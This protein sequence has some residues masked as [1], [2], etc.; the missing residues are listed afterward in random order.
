[1]KLL[2]A[3][4]EFVDYIVVRAKPGDPGLVKLLTEEHWLLD[5]R[6]GGL[7]GYS[8]DRLRKYVLKRSRVE[9]EGMAVARVID[10]VTAALDA[11]GEKGEG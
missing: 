7:H 3:N 1:M 4:I 11:G 5:S 2:S 10:E 6:E 9:R 8:D